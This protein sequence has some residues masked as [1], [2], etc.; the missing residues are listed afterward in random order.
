MQNLTEAQDPTET[1]AL[2]FAQ[3]VERSAE[4]RAGRRLDPERRT[5]AERAAW[6][7][8]AGAIADEVF[9]SFPPPPKFTGRMR[10]VCVGRIIREDHHAGV[11]LQQTL[12][13]LKD[14]NAVAFGPPLSERQLYAAA[15]RAHNKARGSQ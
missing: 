4:E 10:F 5:A 13:D 7:A 9:A 15:E 2:T 11:A 6:R 8:E 3:A 12:R 1:R 14:H